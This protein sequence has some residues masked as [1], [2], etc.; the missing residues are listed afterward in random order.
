MR[1]PSRWEIVYLLVA[2]ILF[3]LSIRFFFPIGMWI[4][5]GALA[6]AEVVRAALTFKD[7]YRV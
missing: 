5:L 2:G 3:W 6:I 7:S 1:S 4:V